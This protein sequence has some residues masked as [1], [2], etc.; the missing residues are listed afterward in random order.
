MLKHSDT[1]NKLWY[2]FQQDVYKVCLL[3]PILTITHTHTHTQQQMNWYAFTF[4]KPRTTTAMIDDIS[5]R[6]HTHTHTHTG[7]PTSHHAN[8]TL[9]SAEPLA[10]FEQLTDPL[11]HA[12]TERAFFYSYRDCLL[13]DYCADDNILRGNRV[14]A[15]WL[16]HRRSAHRG[17]G[18][19]RP[20]S[21]KQGAVRPPAGEGKS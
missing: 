12:D 6:S 17:A 20:F 11:G 18:G 1:M 7:Q 21:W 3:S 13:V 5:D 2:L 16:I 10:W 8:S 19:G 15:G 14:T 9:F 4:I